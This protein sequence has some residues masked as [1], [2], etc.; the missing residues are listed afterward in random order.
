MVRS[1]SVEPVIEDISVEYL[2][3]RSV[4]L[5]E[6]VSLLAVARWRQDLEAMLKS[7]PELGTLEALL[8]D[9]G[10]AS[11]KDG[12]YFYPLQSV[13]FLWGC[14]LYTSPSPRD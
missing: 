9:L 13:E 7:H 3:G 11:V 8:C 4:K 1:G 2:I 14:L 10:K 5:A 12:S 6:A